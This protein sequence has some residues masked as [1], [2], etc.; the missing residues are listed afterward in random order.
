MRTF[1]ISCGLW[2]GLTAAVFAAET[3]TLTNGTS[4]AGDIVKFDDYDVMIHTTADGY[5]NVA[6]SQF[7]QD[8]LKQLAA[9]PKYRPLAEP[10]IEPT[11]SARPAKPEIKVNEVHRLDRPANPSLLGGL[12]G[13]PL[14][15]FQLL[16]VY[17]ANLYAA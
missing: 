10:F 8:A 13:S 3:L 4:V 16:V 12:F 17:G 14:G 5:T 9:T 15:L 1:L 6:W 7:S 11:V 2:L